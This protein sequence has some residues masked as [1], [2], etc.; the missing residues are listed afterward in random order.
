MWL[1]RQTYS[2]TRGIWL[3]DSGLL[4]QCMATDDLGYL[5]NKTKLT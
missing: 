3:P 1:F 5:L 2:P 4:S